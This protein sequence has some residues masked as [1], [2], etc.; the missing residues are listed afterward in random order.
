MVARDDERGGT[1]RAGLLIIPPPCTQRYVP[2]RAT[3]VARRGTTVS[4]HETR[5]RC[6]GTTP[7]PT[8]ALG[9]QQKSCAT[10]LLSIVA[11]DYTYRVEIKST[12]CD[13]TYNKTP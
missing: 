9:C 2:R 11:H 6:R 7:C 10:T 12:T 1:S 4:S 5:V 8:M 13:G 3:I